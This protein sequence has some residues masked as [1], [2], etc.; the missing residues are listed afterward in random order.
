MMVEDNQEID[1]SGIS[2]SDMTPEDIDAILNQAVNESKGGRAAATATAPSV[3]PTITPVDHVADS[4]ASVTEDPADRAAASTQDA[5]LGASP[6]EGITAEETEVALDRIDA[7][8]ADL[9]SLLAQTSADGSSI[10]AN[11]TQAPPPPPETESAAQPDTT[12]QTSE[13]RESTT[14]VANDATPSEQPL[15]DATPDDLN[16]P[17]DFSDDDSSGLIPE[18]GDET[19]VTPQAGTPQV[20]PA[21][22]TVVAAAEVEAASIEEEPATKLGCLLK[23][24]VVRPLVILDKPFAGLSPRIKTMVGLTGIATSVVALATWIVGCFNWR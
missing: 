10:P 9:E 18:I 21:A 6:D 11:L 13:N 22:A 1:A 8:L 7:D 20:D 3:Q 5:A 17:P 24:F 19:E 23:R 2:V 4:I 14:D 16:Q 15:P 12:E